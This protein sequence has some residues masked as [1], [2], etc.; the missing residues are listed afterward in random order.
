MLVSLAL[1]LVLVAKVLASSVDEWISE[2]FIAQRSIAGIFESSP[3]GLRYSRGFPRGVWGTNLAPDLG[4]YDEG[5]KKF[6]VNGFFWNMAKEWLASDANWYD[7]QAAFDTFRRRV[8]DYVCEGGTWAC[9]TAGVRD[10][11]CR[12]PPKPMQDAI[13]VLMDPIENMPVVFLFWWCVNSWVTFRRMN[14]NEDA[15]TALQLKRSLLQFC[16]SPCLAKPCRWIP[17]VDMPNVC[18]VVGPFEDDYECICRKDF[19]WDQETRTCKAINPCFVR[20][21]TP[22]SAVGTLTCVALDMQHPK[23]ICKAEYMGKDCAQLRNACL[24]RFNE[25]EPNGNKNCGVAQGNICNPLLGTDFYKCIC[26]TGW[27]PSPQLP[28]DNCALFNDPCGTGTME[29]EEEGTTNGTRATIPKVL[30][31]ITCQHGGYCISSADFSRAACLCPTTLGGDQMYTGTYCET[32]RGV[33]SSWTQ[34]SECREKSCGISRY[35]WRRR[36]C[37]NDTTYTEDSSSVPSKKP[38]PCF[39]ISEEI[40]PCDELLPCSTLRMTGLF[41]N[42]IFYFNR[43]YIFLLIVAL[44]LLIT[45]ILAKT[46]GACIVHWILRKIDERTSIRTTA[47]E[48]A[49][50]PVDLEESSS[51]DQCIAEQTIE[52]SEQPIHQEVCFDAKDHDKRVTGREDELAYQEEICIG[53]RA[54]KKLF[55]DINTRGKENEEFLRSL[56]QTIIQRV[57]EKIESIDNERLKGL[58]SITHSKGRLLWKQL[59]GRLSYIRDLAGTKGLVR[60]PTMNENETELEPPIIEREPVGTEL[61]LQHQKMV[62][63]KRTDPRLTMKALK[64][65]LF[66]PDTLDQISWSEFTGDLENEGVK[67]SHLQSP[68]R[69]PSNEPVPPIVL[70]SSPSVETSQTNDDNVTLKS[71]PTENVEL[72]PLPVMDTDLR[73]P[74]THQSLSRLSEK[75]SWHLKDERDGMTEPLKMTFKKRSSIIASLDSESIGLPHPLADI[76][77]D[78]VKADLPNLARSGQKSS[79]PKLSLIPEALPMSRNSQVPI[80]LS[81][82]DKQIRQMD[83]H[84]KRDG[85]EEEGSMMPS[86][87]NIAMPNQ[88]FSKLSIDKGVTVQH[89]W[90]KEHTQTRKSFTVE[91]PNLHQS[92]QNRQRQ[93]IALESAD[94]PYEMVDA[95]SMQKEQPEPASQSRSNPTY[96]KPNL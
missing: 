49:V 66:S 53:D 33:W 8:F 7:P 29:E 74:L 27:A 89:R 32:P 5:S 83:T 57:L 50:Q 62:F 3:V 11:S 4:A 67:D 34:S 22:C 16:P 59:R 55:I 94:T 77:Q 14:S 96:S 93:E 24:T 21:Y 85:G 95:R 30:A 75:G 9:C 87:S 92:H 84:D 10:I 18:N 1:A 37:L 80:P 35:R 56:R 6:L 69:M 79:Q 19:V 51:G 41:R 91:Y 26:A 2:M 44:E 20:S 40:L 86:S 13:F 72:E 12:N 42:E 58:K 82:A 61:P 68:L 65:P 60:K 46:C 45:L 52:A 70:I 15:F 76:G 63:K 31:S 78:K 43:L 81:S 25:T 28:Y 36:Q 48:V 54:D 71:E 38:H 39:G 88:R 17:G 47:C 64:F 90:S 73:S 23:C